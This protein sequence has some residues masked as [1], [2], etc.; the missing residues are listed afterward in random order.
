MEKYDH[1]SIEKKWQT[2]WEQAGMYVADENSTKPKKYVLDMFPYP[3]GDGLHLGHVENYTATCIYSR[4]LRMKGFNVM[5]PIGWDAFG[6][7]AENYA[8]KTGT[9][10]DVSTHQNIK[11]FTAQMKS[12]GVSS[13]WTREI[14]TSSPEY[15]RWTQWFFLLLY[16]NGLAYKKKAKVNWCESCKTVL[17]NEQAENGVCERCK[18]EVI[19]KDLEQWFFKITD[20]ADDLIDDL[21]SVDW[22]SSTIAAQRNWIGRSEG[23][24]FNM[25]VVGTSES[26][27]VY[28]TRIDTVFGMTYVVLAP[29]HPLVQ[30]LSSSIKNTAEVNAYIDVT[31]KKTELE[32]TELAKEKTGV[33][34]EG[35]EAINPFTKQPVPVFI[36]DYVLGNYGTGAVMAVPAH[37]ERDF[38]FAKKYNLPIVQV[39]EPVLTQMTGS[40][41]FREDEPVQQSHG[42]IVII[43]HWSEDKYLGLRWPTAGWGTFL[44]G[45][46]DEGFTPEQTALK[47]I[48]EETGYKKAVIV[49]NLGVIHS[50]YY[51]EP[52]KLNRFGHAPTF[53]VELQNGEQDE[54]SAEE[55]SKHEAV[56]LTRGELDTFLTAESHQQALKLLDATLYT[57]S[58][59][60]TCS[61]E[62][63]GLTSEEA[64]E[65][66]A[67]W[68]EKEGLGAK[69]VNYRL[70]DWLVSRQRYWGAPIPIIYCDD[71][72]E[73]AVPEEN[74]PVLL[75]TDVDFRPTGES[76]LK[77]SKTFNDVVCPKCSKPARRE[78]DT[79]DTFV[80]SSWYYFRFADPHNAKEFASRETIE[81]WLPVDMYMGGAEHTVLHLMYAR[82]FTK[83]LKK[84]GYINFDEPFAKLRHQGMILAEDGRKMSKSLG[85]VINPNTIIEEFGADTLRLHEMF[86]G[87]L[88]DMKAWNSTTIVGPRRFLERVWK[89]TEK[90]SADGD[91]KATD[92]SLHKTI[93]KVGDDIEK[94]GFNTAISSLMILVND[95]EKAEKISRNTFETLLILLAPFAPH[96]TEELWHEIG[97]TE[98]VHLAQWPIYDASKCV[99]S[100]TTV[101]IQVNGK[102][103]DTMVVTTGTSDD[104]IIRL[105]LDLP[106]IQKWVLGKEIKKTIVVK[107]KLL[108]IVVGE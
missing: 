94:F 72:G 14:D 59:I 4:Y 24:E 37:D 103:R 69:K 107:G 87:P 65:K 76:P 19:Q 73:V 31:K 40:A 6:L 88:E 97:N 56:W 46:I 13:D 80:C 28:T 20:Y 63:D 104:E 5:H 102:L 91:E 67:V 41:K 35:V 82:F 60:L 68:L 89:L 52:K 12:L 98:S 85:N 3:S 78:A 58:G 96:L 15:Y 57:D 93:K 2:A 53:Y 33:K 51:H 54:V 95:L 86:L 43:K 105:G 55:T 101:A 11:N 108:S 81:K 92:A 77:Y 70:R 48:H 22:P 100:E 38:E 90:V 18:N 32:R 25:S 42:V 61:S 39:I 84:L 44:T 99:E 66:M 27:A 50:K 47:E 71:C 79:M 7:P 9:H 17:A 1:K 16:K 49:R 64:R 34:L 62:F 26:I 30:K 21:S 10:P 106:N 8:I 45:G 23:V 75:P 29:E 83:V 74:L 36:G